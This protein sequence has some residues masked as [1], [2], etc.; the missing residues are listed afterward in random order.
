MNDNI[1]VDLSNYKDRVGARIAPG[2]Y[3]VQV[4]DA[5]LTK[6]NSG[7]PMVNMWLRVT[8]GEFDGQTIVDRLVVTEKSL[9]RIVGFLQAVGIPTPKKTIQVPVRA[10][11]GKVLEVEVADGEPYNGKIK[12]EV[13]GYMRVAGAPR[14]EDFDAM[15]DDADLETSN[16]VADLPEVEEVTEA[17]GELAEAV[18][19]D[20]AADEV[21]LASIEL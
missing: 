17:P 21:D 15:A 12:S 16:E 18:V 2:T 9:F 4:E 3:R 8:G 19:A 7:N 1:V 6:A 10:I 11:I 5:E 20:E 13:R 14:A